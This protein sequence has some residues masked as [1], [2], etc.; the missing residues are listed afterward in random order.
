MDEPSEPRTPKQGS[1]KA[2]DELRVVVEI[3][4]TEPGTALD[5]QLRREQARALLALLAARKEK[6]E[7]AD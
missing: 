5:D 4:Q 6:D 3:E 2:G 1:D 7:P